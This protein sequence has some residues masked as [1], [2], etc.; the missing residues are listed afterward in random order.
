MQLFFQKDIKGD[1]LILDPDESKHLARVL[2]KPIGDLV[3]FTNGKGSLFTCKITDNHPKKAVLQIV[4][5]EFV[6][7]EKHYIHLAIAPTKSPDRMEWM[8]EKI[9]EIGVNEVTFIRSENSEKDQINYERIYKK[10][11]N[12]CKQSFQT[13]LP[14]VNQVRTFGE[15]IHE[16]NWT[17]FQRFIC[18]VDENIPLH[19]VQQAKPAQSYLV[20]VGP[21]GDFAPREIQEAVDQGFAPCSLGKSRLR[22]ETAGL[23]VVHSLQLVNTLFQKDDSAATL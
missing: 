17:T 15:F 5:E 6:P 11:V 21:E 7:Q 4:E 3:Y 9:T 14:E 10:T 23:A 12:A 18:F 1:K 16:K 20:L 8:M 22:T 2:R 13:W 19:L